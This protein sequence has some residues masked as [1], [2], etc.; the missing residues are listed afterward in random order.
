MNGRTALVL[1]LHRL[2]FIDADGFGVV[3]T[4]ELA[5]SSMHDR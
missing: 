2:T 4:P 1:D 5:I 3:L